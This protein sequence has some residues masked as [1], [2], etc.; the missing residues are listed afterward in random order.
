MAKKREIK[1]PWCS[2]SIPADRVKPVSKKNDYGTIIERRCPD[3]Y[4]VLAA[5]LQEEG[6]FFD[7]MRTF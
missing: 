6:G 2:G 5:Y 4:R 1:C 7:K 3:C